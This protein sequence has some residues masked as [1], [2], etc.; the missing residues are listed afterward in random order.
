MRFL[1][2][3][4]GEADD[5][6]FI[7]D[8]I[9]DDDVIIA[10]DAGLNHVDELNIVPDYLIG[11]FDS[12]SDSL[13]EKYLNCEILKYPAKKD[14]TDLELSIELAISKGAKEIVLLC[15]L[16]KRFDHTLANLYSLI[17]PVEKGV[18]SWI[19][20]KNEDIFLINS[21]IELYYEK[22]SILS[23]IPVTSKV[24]GVTTKNL[25]YPLENETL[26][27]DSSRGLSN[28]FTHKNAQISINLGVLAIIVNKSCF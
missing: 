16:G 2:F 17:K 5:L 12:V 25:E 15:A 21:K 9:R 18:K 28:I 23:L 6:S 20:D 3:V 8:L 24:A 14:F 22:N 13:L 10:I 7:K 19:C 27:I 1:L 26:Y 11:D 4:N